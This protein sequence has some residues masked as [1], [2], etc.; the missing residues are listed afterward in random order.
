M[1]E[2]NEA[3][4]QLRA[5]VARPRSLTER[6]TPRDSSTRLSFGRYAGRTL[7]DLARSDPDYLMWLSRTASGI[8]YRTEIYQILGRATASAA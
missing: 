7:S 6:V 3:Y 2:I 8:G 1:R 5:P 4:A